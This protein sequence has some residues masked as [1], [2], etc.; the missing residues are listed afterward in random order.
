M[1]AELPAAAASVAAAAACASTATAAAAI[2]L[3]CSSF[4][5][6]HPSCDF[7]NTDHSAA[8][9]RQACLKSLKA[10][11]GTLGAGR[12]DHTLPGITL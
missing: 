12:L 11:Q 9:V 3:P 10:R 1:L 5:P 2:L 8:R 7:R 4:L 6:N